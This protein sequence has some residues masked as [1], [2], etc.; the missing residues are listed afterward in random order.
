MSPEDVTMSPTTEAGRTALD[1]LTKFRE[2]S[3]DPNVKRV[4]GSSSEAIL[5]IEAEA[6]APPQAT[7]ARLREALDYADTA[8]AV[9]IRTLGYEHGEHRVLVAAMDAIRAA[10]SDTADSER[11]LAD[12]RRKAVAE[13]RERLREAIGDKPRVQGALRQYWAADD[14]VMLKQI[15]VLALLSSDANEERQP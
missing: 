9:C 6:A 1:A 12:I 5:A 3:A 11:W 4:L 15:D 2:W 10:L 13:E 14:E 8:M 7:V